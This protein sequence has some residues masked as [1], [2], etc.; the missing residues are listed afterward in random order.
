M[1]GSSDAILDGEIVAFDEQGRP[2]FER[3]QP[4]MHLTREADIRRRA[5]STPVSYQLF[6]LLYLDGRSLLEE[7][8]EERRR[9]LE[10]LE[11]DGEAWQT[12]A[13]H[14]GDGRDAAR[15]HRR[16]GPRG[17]RRQAPRAPT[18]PAAAAA[19]G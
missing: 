10:G 9:L 2:S 3:L 13:Y 15:A 19:T 6:D 8:Y 5:K 17:D 12:P 18:G 1:L 7:P 14:R 16:A 11:L 4:R